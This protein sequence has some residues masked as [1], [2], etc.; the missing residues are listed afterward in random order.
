MGELLDAGWMAVPTGVVA[1][2]ECSF[3]LIST[4]AIE[5]G[6]QRLRVQEQRGQANQVVDPA[7]IWHCLVVRGVLGQVH[8]HPEVN[9]GAVGHKRAMQELPRQPKASWYRPYSRRT[10]LPLHQISGLTEQAGLERKWVRFDSGGI[11]CTNYTPGLV[12]LFSSLF[13][14]LRPVIQ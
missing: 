7:R 2:L 13:G 1:L 11:G 12:Q 5:D 8:K 6:F 3:S 14:S 10:A 9:W 4:K